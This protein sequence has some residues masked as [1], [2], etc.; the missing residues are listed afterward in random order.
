MKII[1]LKI[2]KQKIV[3]NKKGDILKFISKRDIFFKKFGETYFT[4]IKKNKTKG[5]TIIR[6]IIV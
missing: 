2:L 4:E 1:G 3:N 6:K 5:W